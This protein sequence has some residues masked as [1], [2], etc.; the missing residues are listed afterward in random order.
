MKL[1]DQTASSNEISVFK[2]G[3]NGPLDAWK[4]ACGTIFG[5]SPLNH[6]PGNQYYTTTWFI[7]P[8]LIAVTRYHSMVTTHTQEHIQESGGHINAHRYRV[9]SPVSTEVDGV[10]VV[11]PSGTIVLLDYARPFKSIHPDGQCQSFIIPHGAIGYAPSD[12]AHVVSLP[13]NT[14]LG[15]LIGREMDGLLDQV[16]QGATVIKATDMHRFL[17]CVEV[18]MS[19]DRA[20]ESARMHARE[21][22]KQAIQCFIEANLAT[23]DLNVSMILRNFGVSRASLYRMFEDDDGVRAYINHRRLCRAVMD[24]A[25]NPYERGNIH[26]ISERWG[27]S[28]D[29]SFSRMVRRTF[30]LTP[31]SLFE[32]PVQS[33]E[34]SKETSIFHTLMQDAANRRLVSA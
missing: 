20:S 19:P 12:D 2:C 30:G 25:R 32:M 29:A 17:G 5:V 18:A 6:N 26:R 21:S 14:N 3:Q 22:L 11:S 8:I 1:P 27:F 28:S 13:E 33:A 34:P 16:T 15:H 31:G 4:A 10:P 24:L 7:D 9:E 23:P